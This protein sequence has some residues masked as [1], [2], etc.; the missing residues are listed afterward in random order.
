MVDLYNEMFKSN[1]N[2]SI[3]F[4]CYN[5]DESHY[6]KKL[7]TKVYVLYDTNHIKSKPCKTN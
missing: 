3:I 4:T 2:E 6:K 1:K 7:D 5:K